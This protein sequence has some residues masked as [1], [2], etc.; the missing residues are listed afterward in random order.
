M[1]NK[2]NILVIGNGA[3]E[4][5]ICWSLRKSKKNWEII[6]CIPGSAGISEVAICEEINPSNKRIY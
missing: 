2:L 6:L 1:K 5:A 3:R 4:H